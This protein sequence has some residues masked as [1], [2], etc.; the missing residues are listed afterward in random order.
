MEASCRLVDLL[1]LHPRLLW[2]TVTLATQVV[3]LDRFQ[4][5]PHQINLD[6]R[7]AP[8]FGSTELTLSIDNAG[9]DDD[10]LARLRRTYE[11]AR[12]G[13]SSWRRSRSRAWHCTMRATTRSVTSLFGAA[14]PTIAS[15]T[16]AISSKLTVDGLG[17]ISL[18]LGGKS[19]I[20]SA[21][22]WVPDSSCAW[23][24]SKPPQGVCG[25][26]ASISYGGLSL[27]EFTMSSASS[28]VSDMLVTVKSREIQRASLAEMQADREAAGRHFL[29]AAHLELVLAADYDDVEEHNLAFRSRLSAVSCL[30]RGEQF[31][32]ARRL[33]EQLHEAY[34]ARSES[35]GKVVED[36]ET[37]VPAPAH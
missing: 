22:K 10:R 19:G 2:D 15:E 23:S 11:P 27:Q 4:D 17:L 21:A 14:P 26:V 35:I 32:R 37:N 33:I 28:L 9:V 6:V 30:W 31:D 25:S 3:L 34:P 24:S 13:E 7:H 5:R 36:L 8:G 1:E 16:N 18:R 12:Q 20:V 29:A